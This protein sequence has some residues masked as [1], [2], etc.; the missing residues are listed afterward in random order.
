MAGFRWSAP[1]TSSLQIMSSTE[2]NPASVGLANNANTPAT[3]TYDFSSISPTA[4]R[5]LYALFH[6]TVT[7]GT[8]PTANTQLQLF[9]LPS[10]RDN[11]TTFPDGGSAIL[12][13][14][15]LLVASFFVRNVN[16]VQQI[17]GGAMPILLPPFPCRFVLRNNGTGQALANSPATAHRVD[18]NFFSSESF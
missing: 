8:A 9:L 1:P 11:G 16:T 4:Y 6:A 5:Q 2:L 13:A 12:P 15:N 18:V 3:A 7:F 17:S 10:I 14:G